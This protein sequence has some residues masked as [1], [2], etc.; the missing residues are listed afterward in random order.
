MVSRALHRASVKPVA[1][2][3]LAMRNGDL[4]YLDFGMMSQAPQSARYVRPLPPAPS[5]APDCCTC[6]EAQL[7]CSAEVHTLSKQY[8]QTCLHDM[9]A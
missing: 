1:G 6:C 4:C 5:T 8:L 7:S 9:Q 3:L 2:N